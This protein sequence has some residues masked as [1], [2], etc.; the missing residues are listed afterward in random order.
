MLAV[1]FGVFLL[2]ATL[3]AQDGPFLTID[4][5][6]S[7]LTRAFGINPK[8]DIVGLYFTANN[9]V[10]GF[11]LSRGQYTTIDGPNS[12]RTNAIGINPRGQVVGRYDTPDGVAH[13]YIYTNGA[14]QTVDP[15][16]AA[17]FT[18]VTDVTPSGAIVGRYQAADKSFHG[19]SLAN[20]QPCLQEIKPCE[21]ALIDHLDAN[22][23][24]DMGPMGIQGMG[25]NA[26]GV[27]AGFYQDRNNVFHAFMLDQ[28]VYTIIDP[29]GA[30]NTGGSGGVI[31][32]NPEGEVAGYYTTSDDVPHGFLYRDGAWITFDFPDPAA[33]TGTAQSTNTCGI[34]PQGDVVGTYIDHNNASHGYFAP[35]GTIE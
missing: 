30:K 19:F 5:P 21:W 17:G 28:G 22:G 10:H 12:I 20:T 27:I 1:I 31:H 3:P 33:A 4:P 14:F 26:D 34:N 2:A 24:P 9:V 8:G 23:N 35:R 13:G 7:V 18:V 6:R 25:M 29:P 15:P 16:F 32:I 11:L